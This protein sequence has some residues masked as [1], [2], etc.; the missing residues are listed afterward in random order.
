MPNKRLKINF[1]RLMVGLAAPVLAYVAHATMPLAV[2][3][4]APTAAHA[5]NAQIE[6]IVVQAR[7]R[8][9]T[10]QE[11]PVIVYALDEEALNRYGATSIEELANIVP[12]M[13]I[14]DTSPVQ[15]QVNLRG[16]ES[17]AIGVG[18]DQ[19]VAI[20]IDG[21]QVSNAEFLRS[22]QFD[23]A[24]VEVLKG[25]Q[26]LYFGKNS[27]GGIIVLKSADP[28][29][30][31]YIETRAGYESAAERP[32]GHFIISGPLTEALG[33]RLAVSYTESEGWFENTAP[34]TANS[35]L[36]NYDE[37]IVRGTL[38][39]EMDSFDITAKVAYAE[40]DGADFFFGELIDCDPTAI[41]GFVPNADCSLDYEGSTSDPLTRAN[42]DPTFAP[43]HANEP[44]T[45]YSNLVVGIEFNNDISDNLVFSGITGYTR[46]DNQRSDN[47]LPGSVQ[48]VIG[49]DQVQ[50]TISQE[51]RLAG[52]YD[53]FNFMTGVF[54]DDRKLEQNSSFF[55]FATA[56]SPSGL[57]EID[58][59]S[60]SL[61]AQAGFDLTEQLS[62]SVGGRYLEERREFSGVITDDNGAGA[63]GV[64]FTTGA[65]ITPAIDEIEEQSFSPEVTLTYR[66]QDNV[67]L[68][69]SYKE[70]FKSGGFNTS[71]LSTLRNSLPG[72]NDNIDFGA[73]SASGFEAGIKSQWL[74]NTLRFNFAA[75]DYTY[76]DLQI[77]S[78]N[79]ENAVPVTRV[80]NV[81]EAKV[82]GVEMEVLYVVPT[83]DYLALSLGAQWLDSRYTKFIGQCSQP[84]LATLAGVPGFNEGGCDVDVNNDGTPD[85]QD[86]DGDPLRRAP[87]WSFQFGA[88]YERV[89]ASG[90]RIS[91]SASAN[92]MSDYETI[93]N[94]DPRVLGPSVWWYDAS[95]GIHAADDGWSLELL[96]RNLSDEKIYNFG[97]TLSVSPANPDE[98]YVITR[99]P[100]SVLV[101]FTLRPSVWL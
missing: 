85:A 96:G 40:R 8:D 36:P 90:L 74:D 100:R 81:G 35:D 86:R 52:D 97:G 56:L 49:E 53:G 23:L 99:P 71:Q 46:I 50:T 25:P 63:G 60:W 51:L 55:V 91:G 39:A 7:R 29:D 13:S 84:Q 77:S 58:S 10:V 33:G 79:T 5:Q 34:G 73:E 72:V 19:A 37:L 18:I 78:V 45:D 21:V 70:A 75:F 54:V 95:L 62:L 42:Y 47:L 32:Y 101:Q 48:F 94:G 57:Q 67:N 31:F 88:V 98:A 92:Y 17:G 3:L 11:A 20:N 30:E 15:G 68:F 83:Q 76:D 14:I 24:G 43:E 1:K 16:V 44:Y 69:A 27:P 22:G 9:E 4:M 80:S 82:T 28:T 65:E 87:E 41:Q 93:S 6:E 61:F 2:M 66:P 26:A 38:K 59:R 64:P 12:G 89:L